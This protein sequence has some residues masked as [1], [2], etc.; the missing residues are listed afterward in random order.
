M[1][2]IHFICTWKVSLDIHTTFWL[3]KFVENN[4]KMTEILPRFEVWLSYI[5]ITKGSEFMKKNTKNKIPIFPSF[6]FH[7]IK[8]IY[9]DF[10]GSDGWGKQRGTV[11]THT[12]QISYLFSM[13]NFAFI[14]IYIC[15]N[16]SE[17]SK[18]RHYGFRIHIAGNAHN[19]GVSLRGHLKDL[20]RIRELWYW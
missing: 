10:G 11:L 12:P 9:A 13:H 3:R 8:S 2:T 16:E 5:K 18:E 6:F 19:V 7:R 15:T 1:P 17:L 4:R 14:P 20:I